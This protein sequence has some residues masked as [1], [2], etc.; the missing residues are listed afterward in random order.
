MVACARVDRFS[1]CIRCRRCIHTPPT[2]SVR[3]VPMVACARVDR[4]IMILSAGS[5]VA[6]W[7]QTIDLPHPANAPAVL[8]LASASIPGSRSRTEIDDL[9]A[10]APFAPT[11]AYLLLPCCSPSHPLWAPFILAQTSRPSSAVFFLF[12]R[13]SPLSEHPCILRVVHM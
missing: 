2:S 7:R 4:L 3:M 6:M 11:V 5:I 12:A 8:L 10:N 9:S 13:V 1:K